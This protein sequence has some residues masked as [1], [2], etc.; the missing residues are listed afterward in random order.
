MKV[1]A[2]QFAAAAELLLNR[3]R[4]RQRCWFGGICA[5][6]LRS[7]RAHQ[8]AGVPFSD[9]STRNRPLVDLTR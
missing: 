2:T 1:H 8:M 4:F 7:A 9:D 6:P 5:Y 3:T